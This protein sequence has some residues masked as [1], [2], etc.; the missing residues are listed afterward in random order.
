VTQITIPNFYCY[1]PRPLIN[2]SIESSKSMSNMKRGPGE[3]GY[4]GAD[5]PNKRLRGDQFE[6]R[7]LIPSKVAGSIIGKGGVNIKKLRAD[8]NAAV[9]VPDSPGPE[10]VMTVEAESEEALLAVLEQSLPLMTDEAT[11]R[12]NNRDD[13]RG[14]G[15]GSL[16]IRLLVHQSIVGGI[17][18][19]G[20]SKIK[21]IRDLSGANIKVYQTAAPQSTDRCVSLQGTI[22]KLVPA[23]KEVL[24]VVFKAEARG[25]DQ[26]Y[27]PINFDGFYANEYGGYGS[28]MDVGGRSFGG[29]GGGNQ[30]GAF[31]M[32]LGAMVGGG[33]RGGRGGFAGGRGGGAPYGGGGFAAGGGAMFGNDYMK[34]YEGNLASLDEAGEKETTQVTIPKDTAGAIIGPGGNRIRQIRAESRCNIAIGEVEEGSN[35][36][37]ITIVGTQT[38]IQLAQYLLQQSVREHSRPPASGGRF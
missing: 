34:A 12:R 31:M 22:E 20:G 6:V 33:F 30:G 38:Q 18:G 3:G 11:G 29:K 5:G 24:D 35:D 25:M 13:H 10:R 17:I 19:K 16:D 27:D 2:L 23:I 8:N 4:R 26:P 32:G 37:I 7:L 28:D 15:D 36:R 14:P 21:E 1:T 9:R